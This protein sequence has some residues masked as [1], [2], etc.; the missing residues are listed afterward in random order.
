LFNGVINSKRVPYNLSNI[1][2]YI[3]SGYNAIPFLWKSNSCP[4]IVPEYWSTTCWS[5]TH[6]WIVWL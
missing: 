5:Q 2:C 4:S 1:W 3:S 6:W